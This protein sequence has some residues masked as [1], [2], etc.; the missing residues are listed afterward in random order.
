[1]R[2]PMLFTPITLRG[3]TL[4]HRIVISPM[5]QYSAEDGLVTDWHFVHLG[6]FAQGGAG[7]PGGVAGE[8]RR[9]LLQELLQLLL[10]GP[11][12]AAGQHQGAEPA[13]AR[14][15]AGQGQLQRR[16]A[17]HQVPSIVGENP[18][19]ALGRDLVQSQLR[20]RYRGKDQ[21]LVSH[22]RLAAQRAGPRQVRCRRSRDCVGL[23]RP[24]LA[25]QDAR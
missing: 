13:L 9:V 17:A 24:H 3:I 4:K 22:H 19:P 16:P 7:G 2:Q 21:Q 23:T 12:L 10:Q 1:M 15:L 5:C 14:L 8:A 11:V 6:K 25:G 20:R 18:L